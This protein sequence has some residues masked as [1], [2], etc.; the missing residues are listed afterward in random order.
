M[1]SYKRL[2]DGSYEIIN[3]DGTR[4]IL[5]GKAATGQTAQQ[6]TVE[7]VDHPDGRRDVIA[8]PQPTT[9]QTRNAWLPT[10]TDF[11]KEEPPLQ[12]DLEQI[13]AALSNAL[14]K[15]QVKYSMRP[16]GTAIV[17]FEDFKRWVN[18]IGTGG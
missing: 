18:Q 10:P 13:E 3:N 5:W 9:L 1:K 8:R 17:D 16:D 2:P 4:S 6:G 7:F 15:G 14:R 11:Q 12:V